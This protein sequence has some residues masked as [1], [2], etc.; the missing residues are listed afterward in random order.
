M[1]LDP[2]IS[3]LLFEHDCVI[4]ADFGGFIASRKPA[5]F[6]SALHMFA[7][8]SKVIA[9]NSFLKQNDGLLAD[10][11]S[12]KNGI[13]YAEASAVISEYVR[14][15]LRHLEEGR[16]LKLENIGTIYRDSDRNLQFLPDTNANYLISSFGLSPVHSP[17]VQRELSDEQEVPLRVVQPKKENRR[18]R[19][20]WGIIEVVPA[21]AV[22]TFL[23]MVPPVLDQFN[24][25]LASLIPFSRINEFIY[26]TGAGD[27]Q[28]VTYNVEYTSP[29]DVPPAA[30]KDQPVTEIAGDIQPEVTPAPVPVQSA[31]PADTTSVATVVVPPAV[32]VP[33]DEQKTGRQYFI[34][35]GCFRSIDN[36]NRF[37]EEQKSKG[38][39][40][41]VVGTNA[42][43]LHMVSVFSSDN[44]LQV[45]DALPEF[46]ETV[47]ASVWVHKK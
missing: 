24:H 38:V 34:I 27:K 17:A 42:A 3:E 25:N 32:A 45:K 19:E 14:Q 29:F 46:R 26:E 47:N 4:V 36:A 18:A 35:G 8:P 43:G 28:P 39:E 31:T 22:L 33:V 41:S 7:P 44:F 2:F 9:F 6:N 37:V 40:A 5:T 21:A 13:S 30:S 10:H 16:R 15:S 12:R 23:L 1:K 11:I 20:K